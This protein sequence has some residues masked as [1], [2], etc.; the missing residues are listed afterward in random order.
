MFQRGY[1]FESDCS[2]KYW[3]DACLHS[4]VIAT[5]F[6]VNIIW[7]DARTNKTSGT[8]L[9]ENRRKSDM[10]PNASVKV[11]YN[12]GYIEPS[13]IYEESA[14]EKSIII[15]YYDNHYQHIIENK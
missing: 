2:V 4:P 14:W 1:N 8:V 12:H 3:V 15:L 9:R 7:Y 13:K 6:K 5:M 11:K 10:S